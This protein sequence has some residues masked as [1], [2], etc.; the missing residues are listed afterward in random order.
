[1]ASLQ[2]SLGT[3]LKTPTSFFSLIKST[4]Q[5]ILIL[6]MIYALGVRIIWVR[7]DG[8]S[9]WDIPMHQFHSA[10]D[11]EIAGDDTILTQ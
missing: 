9:E 1:M 3:F 10:F 5:T 8:M 4:G 7:G 6:V 2:L 11:L